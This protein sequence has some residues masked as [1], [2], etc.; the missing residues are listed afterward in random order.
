MSN[1]EDPRWHLITR[2]AFRFCVLYFGLYVISTQMLGSLLSLEADNFAWIQR[3]TEW[4]VQWIGAHVL[5]VVVRTATT[6]SGDRMFDWVQ[7]VWLLAVASF[8]TLVWS[9]ADRRRADYARLDRW[10][11]IFLRFAVGA[12]FLS[13]GIFKVF[14][15][16][17]PGSLTRLVEPFGNFSPMGV[18]WASVG[19]SYPYERIAGSA[20]IAGAVLLFIPRTAGIGAFVCLLDALEIFSLN[21]T[22]DVPVKLFSFHLIVMSLVLGAPYATRVL[23]VVT[24][25]G[26]RTWWS[27]LLQLAFGAYLVTMAVR[28]GDKTWRASVSGGGPPPPLYGIWVVD[29]MTF[30]GATHP[31]VVTDPDR[32]RR[33]VIQNPNAVT[34]CHMDDTLST[35]ASHT[36]TT[37]KV[38]TVS[39]GQTQVGKFWFTQPSADRLVFDGTLYDHQIH[40]SMA[41]VDRSQFPLVTRGFHWV[42]EYPFNR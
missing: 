2:I 36:D 8:L 28:F 25:S 19:A 40:A 34:F 12:T 39:Q 16:Q 41:L 37:T 38:V 17:M 27:A 9:V 13:Y 31:P 7:A 32:W 20:E 33:V 4:I 1:S 11:R 14:P 6:G 42:Q 18:L 35:Y 29:D 24:S 22:Y 3:A 21:M 26:A 5:H 30:D 23:K 10:F 15:L